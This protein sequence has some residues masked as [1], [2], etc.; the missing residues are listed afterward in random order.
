MQCPAQGAR[1]IQAREKAEKIE[2]PMGDATRAEIQPQDSF[3]YLANSFPEAAIMESFREVERTLWEMVPFLGLP[4][5]ARTPPYVI[6]EMRR[7]KYIDDNTANLFDKL[8]EARNVAA[9]AG[10]ANRVGPGDALEFREQA[11]T[12][13]ELLRRVLADMQ[14]NPPP[15]AWDW[16]K[17]KAREQ[18]EGKG[19]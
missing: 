4:T 12:L 5:K 15:Q 1:V 19:G 11:R 14:T 17:E 18:A 3:L 13:N 8:R 6:E 9:H 10:N 2:P 7:M 16:V